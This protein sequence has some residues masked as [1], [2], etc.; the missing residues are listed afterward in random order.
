MNETLGA[1]LMQFDKP[2]L[3]EKRIKL[4]EA[5][6][7]CGSITTAA[8]RVG[9]SYKTA[10]EAIDTMNNLSQTPL[11]IR[12]TGGSGGGGTTLT[13]FG[14]EMI[15]NY[16]ILKHEYERFIHHL[17]SL[18]SL[19]MEHVK[20]LQR[21]NMHISA[22]NQLVG[23]IHSI[24]EGN[25]S[26]EVMIELKSGAKLISNIT[27]SAVEELNL[28]V[29]DEVVGI[30]KASSVLLT[31]T[32][33]IVTSARNKLFGTICDIKRGEVNAQVSVDIG[34]GDVITATIT[35]ESV[36]TLGLKEKMHVCAMIKS[37]SILIGK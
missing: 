14:K 5:I 27:H 4:L 12:T 23:K 3:L 28:H 32:L 7:D 24:K 2:A 15:E 16:S 30:I 20:H 18:S 37:S 33:N 19:S 21:I 22:R 8:K 29:G 13:P 9:L 11:V 34:N 26:A 10:W 17:S 25:V 35:T 6:L 36:D 1:G 31:T